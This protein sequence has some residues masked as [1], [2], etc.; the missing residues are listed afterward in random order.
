MQMRDF[1]GALE[2]LDR[3]L[4]TH[5]ERATTWHCRGA[6]HLAAQFYD[7][8]INDFSEALQ[9]NPEYVTALTNRAAAR[10]QKGDLVA[11]LE[12]CD[13]ALRLVPHDVATL[14]NRAALRLQQRDFEG[15]KADLDVVLAQR[16]NAIAALCNRAIALLALQQ[17]EAGRQDAERVLALAPHCVLGHLLRGN[18]RHHQGD[19]EALSDYRR[20]FELDPETAATET[21]RFLADQA[22]H[23]F[24]ETLVECRRQLVRHPDDALAYGRRGLTWLLLD[25]A[26][27]AVVDFEQFARCAANDLPVLERLQDAARAIK[28][29]S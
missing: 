8:A 29:L 27:E 18:A 26:D 25:R 13:A 22:R 7:A 28:R 19:P 21:I 2:D 10:A 1:K 17:L 16:P 15:A 4:A 9:L 12:D 23:Q 24:R 11:A 6:V 14:N 20:A 5:P 3:V